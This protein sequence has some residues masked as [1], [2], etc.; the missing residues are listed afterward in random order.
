MYY[1]RRQEWSTPSVRS[2]NNMAKERL[3]GLGFFSKQR[4]SIMPQ[5]HKDRGLS[6]QNYLFVKMTD[7]F[8]K[9][10]SIWNSCGKEY[11]V[12]IVREQN[13]CLFPNYTTFWKWKNHM[14]NVITTCFSALKPK[15]SILKDKI[16]EKL[17]NASYISTHMSS[18]LLL[19][20]R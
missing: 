5:D 3:V 2:Y 1:Q 18:R 19:S 11:I 7:P 12:N 9:L 8:S 16:K 10:T 14:G 15:N 6:H 20:Q 4:R 13:N 17:T